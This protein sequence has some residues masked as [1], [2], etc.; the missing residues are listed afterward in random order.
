MDRVGAIVPA[1]GRSERMEGVDKLLAP[2]AGRPLLA[3]CV[4]TLERNALVTEIV[5]SVPLEKMLTFDALVQTSNW[6]RT[7]LVTGGRRRQDSVANA[8]G[9]LDDVDWIIVHDGDRP[10]LTEALIRNG[11]SAARKTGVAVAA[12]TVKDTVKIVSPEG[13]VRDTLDRSTLRAVQTPQVFRADIL[14]YVYNY[15]EETVTDDAMLAERLGYQVTVY[16]GL[17]ENLKVT[18][19]D[20]LLVAQVIARRWEAGR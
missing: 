10:F 16:E 6:E 18:T 17:C 12:V 11:I 3:W 5:V 19:P 4:D 8:L 9:V 7:R 2:L 15:I 20:D 1:S 14:R 13:V